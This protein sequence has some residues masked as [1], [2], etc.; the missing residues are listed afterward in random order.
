M[1]L[2]CSFATNRKASSEHRMASTENR[3]AS[4]DNRKLSSEDAVTYAPKFKEMVQLHLR[5]FQSF[6][7]NMCLGLLGLH[8]SH[9][10]GTMAEVVPQTHVPY[11][12]ILSCSS[13]VSLPSP[14]LVVLHVQ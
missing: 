4:S 13:T 14:N 11:A 7:S 9:K 6:T 3:M 12:Q 5:I 1:H 8:L 10:S 2:W